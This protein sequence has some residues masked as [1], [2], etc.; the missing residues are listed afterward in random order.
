MPLT[1]K[2]LREVRLLYA[3]D[4]YEVRKRTA[5]FLEGY[6]KE[7]LSAADGEEALRLFQDQAPDIIL[8]DVRMPGLNGIELVETIRQF[9]RNIPII[10]LSAHCDTKLLLDAI[11]LKLE[12]Y[13]IKPF[14]KEKLIA[15]L[16][17]AAKTLPAFSNRIYTFES[18]AVYVFSQ[19]SIVKDGAITPLTHHESS[20]MELLICKA[21]DVITYDEIE[22]YVYHGNYMSPDAIKTLVKKLRKKLPDTVI[23]NIV[24]VG[25]QLI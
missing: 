1:K 8:T 24:N 19:K 2:L 5:S 23:K 10:M 22:T 21:G 11:R 16:T 15:V 9:D 17:D 4:E 20:L 3:E 25:Y 13:L 7:V 18:G 12:E 14:P 6:F